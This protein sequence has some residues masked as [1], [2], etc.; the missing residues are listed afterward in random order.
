MR[1]RATT[2]I[3]HTQEQYA[4]ARVAERGGRTDVRID[5]LH[6]DETTVTRSSWVSI[7]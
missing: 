4:K 3:S 7:A 1:C 6:G 5:I 2:D